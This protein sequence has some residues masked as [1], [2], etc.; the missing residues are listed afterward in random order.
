MN[1]F[2]SQSQVARFM[3]IVVGCIAIVAAMYVTSSILTPILLGAL[4]A[5]SV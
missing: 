5:S 3:I 1:H 2:L 4:F